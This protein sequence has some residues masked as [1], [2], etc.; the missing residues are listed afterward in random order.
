MPKDKGP[1]WNHVTVVD[2]GAIKGA[3]YASMKCLYCEKTFTGGVN[4]IRA[5]L[6]G[7]STSISK[8]ENAPDEPD[9]VVVA[10]KAL[11]KETEE[12]SRVSG[13]SMGGGHRGHVPLPNP[14]TYSNI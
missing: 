3:A 1:E 7:G 14:K 13:G 11:N 4:R 9:E 12:R 8:C 6:T 5:H 10:M 2:D